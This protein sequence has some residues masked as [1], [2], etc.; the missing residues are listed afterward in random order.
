MHPAPA[1]LGEPV[2]VYR[3]QEVKAEK[4]RTEKLRTESRG[5][6]WTGAIRDVPGTVTAG[7]R[8]QKLNEEANAQSS[9]PLST[10]NSQPSSSQDS[11]LSA[12][13]PFSVSASTLTPLPDVVASALPSL[14]CTTGTAARIDR[15]DDVTLH[16]AFFEWD[17][18]SST[19]VLEAFKHLPEEC[20]GSIGMTLIEKAPVRTFEV[21][22]QGAEDRLSVVGGPLSEKEL[23]AE[24]RLSVVS[25]QLS[26][27]ENRQPTTDHSSS[28]SDNRQLTTDNSSSPTLSFDHTVFRDPRGVMVHAFKG[29]WVSGATDLLGPGVRGGVEQWNEIRRKAAFKRFRPAH[30][31]VIQGAVRGIPDADLAW[32]AFE[33]A[34]LKDLSFQ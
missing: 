5:A 34:M 10:L 31:R 18:T 32:Q 22:G 28:P 16:I 25:G 27:T 30:A 9:S 7:G 4:L 8:D 12:S 11:S 21:R 1:G 20:M 13:Q 6:R 19:N 33:E 3:P 14:R 17:L 26:A 2:L 24:D 15:D 23:A 29:T